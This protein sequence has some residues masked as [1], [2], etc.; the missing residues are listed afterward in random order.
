MLDD[1]REELFGHKVG[2]VDD[3]FL[4]MVKGHEMVEKLEHAL[5]RLDISTEFFPHSSEGGNGTKGSAMRECTKI[6]S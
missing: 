1:V 3:F 5:Q 4:R 2:F 6:L